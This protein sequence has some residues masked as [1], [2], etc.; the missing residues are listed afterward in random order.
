M[1][2]P[3]GTVLVGVDAGGTKTS[4]LAVR[5][6][7]TRLGR[8]DGDGANPK[9]QGLVVA[10]ERIAA[11]VGQAANGATP[12]LVYIA[13]A[14]ID[15]PEQARALEREVGGR[16]PRSAVMAANDT[17]AVLRSGTADGV[18]LVVPVSTGGNVIGR[19][20]DGQVTD[21]GHGIFGG[22]YVM[23]A[24]AARAARR[25]ALSGELAAAVAGLGLSWRGRRP[26][27]AAAL[28]GAAVAAAAEDGE[29]YPA[30]IVDRWCRRVT[31]AVR[32]E[33]DRLALGT[34]PV[35]IVYGGLLDAS[36]WLGGR[37]RAAVLAGAPG[38]RLAS[39]AVAPVEGAA[40]L[41]GD[42][43]AGR[44]EPW[45]FTPRR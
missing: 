30:R 38:A 24:L 37:I 4:A 20:R 18:G 28:L 6:D 43:W 10:A 45:D 41:A 39:L 31:A 25:G 9:R 5:P 33:V 27:P 21:R 36:P 44:V 23:G 40:L 2:P 26:E 42:A 19:G 34:D 7:G 15:R 12:E 35:V 29:T 3:D 8:A 14:G 22:T 16:L 13:G 32:E 17:M 1:T 11:L